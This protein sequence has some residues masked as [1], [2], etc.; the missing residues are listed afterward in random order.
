VREAHFTGITESD[1]A[2]AEGV[3]LC[4]T[5][6]RDNFFVERIQEFSWLRTVPV[7]VLG[8][9]A[10]MEVL[11]LAFG[12][13]L[14]IGCGIGLTTVRA[15]APDPVLGERTEFGAYELHSFACEPA[16]GWIVTSV[17]DG[18]IQSFRHPDRPLFGVMFHPEVRNDR[19]VE[20]FLVLCSGR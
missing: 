6:L 20:R 12:G 8:I 5:A 15:C 10:G 1:L 9:C 18:C 3:I 16:P 14:R 7:P 17:S 4:G 13:K 19:V 11:C 2:G